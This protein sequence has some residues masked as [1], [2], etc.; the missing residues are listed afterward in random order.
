MKNFDID[1]GRINSTQKAVFA[2]HLSVMLKAGIT[3]S[4]SL[5]IIID[6]SSGKLKRIAKQI[7]LSVELGKNLSG[8]LGQYPKIFSGVFISA[9]KIGEKSGTLHANLESLAEQLEKER[10]MRSKVANALLYPVVVLFAALILGLV[11]AFV[12]LPKI[13][14]LFQGLKVSLPL[15]TRVLIWL[16]EVIKNYGIIIFI[17][18]LVFLFFSIWFCRQKFSHPITHWI[19]LRAPF[20]KNLSININLTFFCQT[21]GMLLKSGLSIDEALKIT[22]DSTNNYYYKKSLKIIYDEIERGIPLATVLSKYDSLYPKM[23]VRM[24]LVG[25]K[26]G[27]LEESLFYL[28]DFYEKEVDAQTKTFSSSIEPLLLIV[29]GLVVGFLALSIITPIYSITSGIKH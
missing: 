1:F 18:I 12:V 5:E 22:G 29:I 11:I 23:L 6:S 26:S 24:I 21:L 15:S 10:Q 14:P 27:K 25:E 19:I 8:A 13:V 20:I 2:K 3:L 16:S 17:V 9:V 7:L 28:A 4:E